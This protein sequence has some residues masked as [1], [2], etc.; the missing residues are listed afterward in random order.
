M[1]R[2]LL[3]VSFRGYGVVIL[4]LGILTPILIFGGIRPVLSSLALGD[5]SATAAAVRD[6]IGPDILSGDLAGADSAAISFGRATG[7]RVT[8][9]APDGTVMMDTEADPLGMENHRTRPE[10]MAAFDSGSGT[11]MRRSATLGRD[12]LYAAVALDRSG[13]RL[14]VVRVSVPFRHLDSVISGIASRMGLLAAVAVALSILLAWHSSRIVSGPVKKLAWEFARIQRGDYEVRAEP[15]RIAELDEL[16]RGFNT[17]AARTGTLISELTQRNSQFEAILDSAS[18]PLAV[19]DRGGRFVFANHAFR[20]LGVSG[21]FD[22]RDY[23]ELISSPELLACIHQALESDAPGR[24]RVSAAGRTW[25]FSNTPVTGY[26]QVVV[27]LADV[28]EVVKLAAVKRDFAVNVAHELRTPLTAIKGFAETLEDSTTGEGRKYL[29]AILR[30]ADRLISLVRDVQTLSLIESPGFR[31][32]LQPLDFG[33]IIDLV[34]ELFRPAAGSKGLE[35]SFVRENVRPVEGDAYRLEQVLINLLDNALKYTDKGSVRVTLREDDGQALLEVTDT[36]Q[37]IPAEEIPRLCE[38]FYVVDKSRSRQLG[39]TGLGLAI[40]KHIVMLHGGALG[41]R[42][43]PG[44]GS[45][46]SVRLPLAEETR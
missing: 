46:F 6:E 35:L 8:V 23:R 25:A 38:R 13:A 14:A 3:L 1:R 12:M 18:G 21:S 4:V 37:G 31:L 24:G 36:G 42:S 29:D 19:L 26:E 15:S 43:E 7:L 39:G 11:A 28:T 2:A 34:L 20:E 45:T 27:S 40:V 30:N 22:D 16:S 33:A 17:A 10:I 44:A 5:L 41:I 9:I 32:D